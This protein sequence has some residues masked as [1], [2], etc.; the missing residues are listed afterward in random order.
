MTE[1]I[2]YDAR[3]LA[4]TALQ[5]CDYPAEGSEPV[6]LDGAPVHGFWA[7]LDRRSEAHVYGCDGIY[8]T[9]YGPDGTPRF[10]GPVC[11]E[12]TND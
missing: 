1:T 9:G 12:H 2:T 3:R 11:Q 10:D 5:R 4:C 8:P 6:T 7:E